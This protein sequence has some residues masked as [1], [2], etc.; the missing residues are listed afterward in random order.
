MSCTDAAVVAEFTK[1]RNVRHFGIRATCS[2]AKAERAAQRHYRIEYANTV[3]G[4]ELRR[5]AE[6]SPDVAK[7]LEAREPMTFPDRDRVN[8]RLL[9]VVALP[10]LGVLAIILVWIRSGPRK[11][12]RQVARRMTVPDRP[13]KPHQD[14]SFESVSSID[15]E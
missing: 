15:H 1:A 6:A 3:S 7:Q 10:T 11:K 8:L 13:R 12:Y 14:R 2:Y 4:W 9:G 5:I